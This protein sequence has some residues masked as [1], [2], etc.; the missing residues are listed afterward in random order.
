M[1]CSVTPILAEEQ[2]DEIAALTI[3]QTHWT[4]ASFKKAEKRLALINIGMSEDEFR[5]TMKMQIFKSNGKA[6][7]IA[8]DGWISQLGEHIE[9]ATNG[10]IQ[11]YVFGFVDFE[12]ILHENFF[13]VSKDGKIVEKNRLP[14]KSDKIVIADVFKP[15]KDD[16][17]KAALYVKDIK[18]GMWIS[19]VRN[20]MRMIF[21]WSGNNVNRMEIISSGKGEFLAFA[22]GF[23]RD[24]YSQE[25]TAEG[26]MQEFVFGYVENSN[27][28]PRFIIHV[29]NLRVIGVEWISKEIR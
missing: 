5:Q 4:S 7:A 2:P 1:F 27:I 11:T 17:A 29:N 25:K 18:S 20:I 15:T 9:S 10:N 26:L 19:E 28:I 21:I 16:Y 12:N 3:Q 23:L 8:M 22:P 24:K 13:V 6:I 14:Q